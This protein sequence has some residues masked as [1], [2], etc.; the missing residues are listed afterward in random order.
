MYSW[1]VLI[2]L[3]GN[4]F[5]HKIW[6]NQFLNSEVLLLNSSLASNHMTKSLFTGLITNPNLVLGRGKEF[7]RKSIIFN[8]IDKYEAWFFM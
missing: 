3:W 7:F 6:P 4:Q 2:L 8:S 5:K 1:K